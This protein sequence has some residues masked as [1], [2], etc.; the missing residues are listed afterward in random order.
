MLAQS[1]GA[2]L[3]AYNGNI[4]EERTAARLRGS[5]ALSRWTNHLRAGMRATSRPTN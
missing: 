5:V 1:V 2:T 3:D 4:G